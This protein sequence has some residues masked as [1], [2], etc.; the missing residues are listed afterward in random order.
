[1][2]INLSDELSDFVIVRTIDREWIDVTRDPV[3]RARDPAGNS[4]FKAI[5]AAQK[6]LRVRPCSLIP[7]D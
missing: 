5:S 2:Q 3:A 4:K 7:A 6:G 1:M